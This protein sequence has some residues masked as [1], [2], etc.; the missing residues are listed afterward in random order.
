M[1]LLVM[2][3]ISGFSALHYIHEMIHED[4]YPKKGGVMTLASVGEWFCTVA[5]GDLD[6]VRDNIDTYAG[7]RSQNGDTALMVAA[8]CNSSEIV[9][10]LAPK[11]YGL[12]NHDGYTALFIAIHY[13]SLAAV[14]ILVHYE[15]YLNIK[16][17]LTPLHYAVALNRMTCIL[18]LMTALGHER[19]MCGRTPTD[20]AYLMGHFDIAI[21]LSVRGYNC[22]PS[23]SSPTLVDH[24]HHFYKIYFEAA[25][26]IPGAE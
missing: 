14:E 11:E 1:Y 13:N 2:Q 21:F 18:P 5:F 7:A 16:E 3:D 26:D 10:I 6:T 24:V 12:R 20:L 17:R 15:A 8:R 22:T 25:F 9:R 23:V 4:S 19:D